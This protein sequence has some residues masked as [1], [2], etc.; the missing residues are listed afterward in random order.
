MHRTQ[1]MLTDAQYALL[2]AES[3]RSGASLAELVR[4]ALEAHF[5]SRAADERLE[6][7]DRSFGAWKEHEETGEQY[8]ER[9]RSGTGRRLGR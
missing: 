3:A 7:L 6:L 9:V 5:G 4:R 2:Q 8:V 1:V